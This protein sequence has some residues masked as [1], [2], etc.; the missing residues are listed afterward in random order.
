MKKQK[1][2]KKKAPGSSVKF[3]W[4][5]PPGPDQV[6]Y[7]ERVVGGHVYLREI[8]PRDLLSPS[9][10]ALALQVRREFI[11]QLIWSG[12]MKAVKREGR[13]AIPFSEVKKYD[14]RRTERHR[15]K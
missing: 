13:N 10:A 5:N 7:I 3:Y 9:E 4:E 6:G 1:K 11:Y 2:R 15:R 8:G 14:E 12:K